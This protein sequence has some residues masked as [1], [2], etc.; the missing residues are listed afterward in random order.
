MLI[1]TNCFH[2]FKLYAFVKI[3]AERLGQLATRKAA[4]GSC[5]KIIGTPNYTVTTVT[6]SL[7][8]IESKLLGATR[9]CKGCI[10]INVIDVDLKKTSGV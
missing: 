3:L 6:A 5:V 10:I 4:N 9:E 2:V 1:K 7:L 8:L